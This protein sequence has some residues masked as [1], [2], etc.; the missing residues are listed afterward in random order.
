MNNVPEFDLK[1]VTFVTNEYARNLSLDYNLYNK[2]CFIC[3]IRGIL[4]IISMYKCV[5]FPNTFYSFKTCTLLL[6]SN[7]VFSTFVI[8]WNNDQENDQIFQQTTIRDI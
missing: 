2:C 1:S 6:L 8:E 4:K 3:R 7:L 5:M